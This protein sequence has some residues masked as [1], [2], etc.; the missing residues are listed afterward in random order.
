MNF[1]EA[2]WRNF[3]GVVGIVFL[4]GAACVRRFGWDKFIEDITHY[5]NYGFLAAVGGAFLFGF[6]WYS[7]KDFWSAFSE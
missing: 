4:L 3:A 5:D 2:L 7:P 1:V 6:A